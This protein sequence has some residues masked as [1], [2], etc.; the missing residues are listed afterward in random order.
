MIGLDAALLCLMLNI[1]H[2]AR[3]ESLTA[4]MA[5][6]EVTMNRVHD[7]RFPNDVCGVVKE[8]PHRLSWKGTGEM[9][10][11]RHK[12]AFSW[13]CDGKSDEMYNEKSAKIAELIAM[14]YLTGLK[15]NFTKGATHY[16][17]AY[18]QP[19]WADTLTKTTQIDLHIFYK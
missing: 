5:V 10:P 1:Y 12:C 9:I 17:A 13:Y 11:V 15:T 3:S 7:E 6:A 19:F 18:V 8:G 14:D 16:H 4:M 2:E